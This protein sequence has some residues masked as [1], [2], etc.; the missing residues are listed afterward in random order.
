VV[1]SDLTPLKELD[2]QRARAEN[3]ASLQR[4]TQAVAHEI[5]N[6]LVPIK[7]LTKLLPERFGD[8]AFADNVSR[9]VSREIERIE[10]LVAR[11][12]RIAPTAELSH[13]L[14]DLRTPMRHALEVVEAAAADQNT[15]LDGILPPQ[16]VLVMGDSAEIE[17]LFLNLITNALEAVVDQPAGL[18]CIQVS[19]SVD[20][21]GAI[22]EIRDTGQGIAADLVDRIF[23]PFVTTKSRG[24]GLGLAICSGIVERH[25]GQL[26]AAN[27]D[28]G[29]AV[30]T[31]ILPRA[32]D[33]RRD[34]VMAKQED[35]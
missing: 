25:H 27:A 13:S 18:R 20:D 3:L 33:D 23:D 26:G 12:R 30:I 5:G 10:R 1:F 6:P 17:E 15:R 14:V 32:E 9:I 22:A 11:L 7:T 31:M 24:S 34:G 8:R 29:G 35:L 16:P 4:M 28:S 21:R 19:V 2:K